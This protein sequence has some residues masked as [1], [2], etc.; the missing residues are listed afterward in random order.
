MSARPNRDIVVVGASAG[1]VEALG[2]L[3]SELPADLP[4]AVFVVLHMLPAGGSLL[5]EILGRASGLPVHAAVHGEPIERGRVYVASPDRHL[6]IAAGRVELSD[7]PAEDG[8]RPAVNPLFRSAARAYGARVVG[9]VLSGALDDG[10]AG[11]KEIV[12]KGGAAIVQDPSDAL[13][14]SMP[15]AALEACPDARVVPIADMADS[16]WTMTAD[17]TTR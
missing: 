7:D 15:R 11:L 2:T 5:P 1:G 4:A 8:H 13:Y 14:G 9:I 12:G 3:V 10:A 17:T 6:L 16:V